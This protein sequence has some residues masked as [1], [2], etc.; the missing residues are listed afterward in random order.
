MFLPEQA[1]DSVAIESVLFLPRANPITKPLA[2]TVTANWSGRSTTKAFGLS[3]A[4]KWKELEA[5]PCVTTRPGEEVELLLTTSGGAEE[6]TYRVSLS[7][8]EF[9]EARARGGSVVKEQALS[10]YDESRNALGGMLFLRF[11]PVRGEP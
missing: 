8:G 10:A 4:G 9:E 5:L 6:E 1:V 3:T 7:W 2:L 11:R